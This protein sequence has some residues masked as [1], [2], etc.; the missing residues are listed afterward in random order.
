MV[1]SIFTFVAFNLNL[2]PLQ[3]PG[4]D[5]PFPTGDSYA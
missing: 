3:S 1:E 5:S 4:D 2:D